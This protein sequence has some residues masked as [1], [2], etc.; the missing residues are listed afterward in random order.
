MKIL[1]SSLVCKFFDKLDFCEN[2]VIENVKGSFFLKKIDNILSFIQANFN[3]AA[4]TSRF[5]K[6]IDFMILMFLS[7]SLIS[8]TFASTG[9]IGFFSVAAFLLLLIK[10]FAVKGERHNFTS[11]DVPIFLYIAIAGVSVAFSSLLFPSLKGYT[12]MIIY[13]AGYLTFFNVL[14][15][16]P[17]RIIYMLCLVALTAAGEALYAISQQLIGIEPLASWQDMTEVNPEQLMNRVYGSLKP[18]NP[19]L[20]AGYLI[21]TFSSSLGMSFWFLVKKKWQI[22]LAFFAATAAILLAILFTGSRGAYIA[23]TF[24]MAVFVFVSGHIIWHEYGHVKWLK[25]LWIAGIIIGIVGVICLVMFSPSLQHRVLSIF[26]L[27]GDSSNSFRLNVYSACLKIFHDNWLIG[28]GPGNTTFR[29]IYGLYMIT[30]FD[31]LGAYCVPLEV[32]VES[33]IFGLLAFLWILFL[34]AIKSVKYINSKNLIENKVLVSAC[35]IGITGMTAH[36]F[37]DTIWYRPQVNLIFWLLVAILAVI[38]SKNVST[39]KQDQN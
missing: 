19:N 5:V 23:M 30:G 38:T 18:F 13:F 21:A 4:D 24:V 6:N 34:C 28:I 33:G 22:S 29:L 9:L 20:L 1:E 3:K 35:L 7:F 39:P 14:K 16:H 26:A 25:K 15:N 10:F 27:R 37:V 12:K 32:A 17:K 36:G 8:V 2:Q 31:A 11:F